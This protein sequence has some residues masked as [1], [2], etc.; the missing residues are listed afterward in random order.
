MDARA[1]M[2]G[3]PSSTRSPL[4]LIAALLAAVIVGWIGGYAV[5]GLADTSSSSNAATSP[6]PS[7]VESIPFISPTIAPTAPPVLDQN[8][9]VVHV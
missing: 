1:T 4:I 7:A 3:I 8:G 6:H 2:R 9:N 5:R